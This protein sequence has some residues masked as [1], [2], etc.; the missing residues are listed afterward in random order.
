[1]KWEYAAAVEGARDGLVVL[2]LTKDYKL[3]YSELDMD[4]LYGGGYEKRSSEQTIQDY[5]QNGLLVN[6]SYGNAA[7]LVEAYIRQLMR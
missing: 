3:V 1:M 2:Y 7:E 4:P 6:P 5:A